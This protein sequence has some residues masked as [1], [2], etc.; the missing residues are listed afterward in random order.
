M[1]RS[2]QRVGVLFFGRRR[3]GFDE[4]WGISMANRVR[5]AVADQ[6][7]DNFVCETKAV[8]DASLRRAIDECG[9]AGCK[10][11]VALQ[12][13]MSDGRLAPIFAQHWGRPI[14]LWGT[15]EKPD[16]DLVSSCSLVGTHLFASILARLRATF[17]VVSGAPEDPRLIEDLDSAVLTTLAADRLRRAKIGLIGGHAPGFINMHADPYALNEKLGAELYQLGQ[18]DLLRTMNELEDGDVSADIDVTLALGMPLVDIQRKDLEVQSRYYLALKRMIEEERFDAL[19]LRCWPELP[20]L[21]GQWPYLAVVRLTDEGYAVTIEGD[22]DGAIGLLAMSELGIEPGFLTDWLEHDHESIVTWHGGGTPASLAEPT[23]SAHGRTIARHFNSNKPAVVDGWIVAD[24]PVT[25]ARIWSDPRPDAA[26]A[27]RMM[28][29]E[30]VTVK[31]T[32]HLRGTNGRIRINGEDIHELFDL[33]CHA[34][35]PHHLAV[36]PGHHARIIG[37]LARI[38]GMKTI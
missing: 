38:L 18:Q 22:V 5:S 13:T 15:P 19:A 17:E 33:V 4:E 27:Y 7:W 34:G 1:G 30:A 12:T 21:T 10:T 28:V 20:N 29:R 25:I 24:R 31:P 6:S 2:T 11:L 35:M 16:G 26:G 36:V 32:R 8:D 9:E 3:P 23:G 14:V 37:R